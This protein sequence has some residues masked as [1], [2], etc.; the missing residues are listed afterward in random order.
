MF[1]RQRPAPSWAGHG[2]CERRTGPNRASAAAKLRHARR[3]VA[4]AAGALLLVHFLAGA[5]NLRAAKRLMRAGLPLGELPAQHAGDEVL[6]RIEAE[7]RL[8]ELQGAGASPPIDVTSIF[9]ILFS[10]GS[11]AAA[12]AGVSA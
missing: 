7:D 3:A 12:A 8:V 9:M 11:A 5:V 1:E 2:H 6:A 10:F 4:G